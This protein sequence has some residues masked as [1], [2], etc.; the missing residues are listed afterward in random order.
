MDV[1]ASTERSLQRVQQSLRPNIDAAAELVAMSAQERC[2]SFVLRFLMLTAARTW[3]QQLA[4][5]TVKHSKTPK[6]E[7]RSPSSLEGAL[8]QR[9]IM[10]A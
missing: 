4:E 10:N 2:Q 8:S 7:H 3:L 1:G 9:Q 5:L 6:S